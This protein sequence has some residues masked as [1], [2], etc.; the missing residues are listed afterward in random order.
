MV[1]KLV[2]VLMFVVLGLLLI[3]MVLRLLLKFGDWR[4]IVCV[5][6]STLVRSYIS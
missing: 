5:C 3:L 1:L 4:H 6:L 2:V